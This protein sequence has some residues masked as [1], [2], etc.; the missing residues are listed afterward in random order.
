MQADYVTPPLQNAHTN[1]RWT[2]F[3][4]ISHIPFACVVLLAVYRHFYEIAVLV[5]LVLAISIP[6]HIGYERR[7]TIS[8]IDNCTA[9]TLSMYGNVQLF[10]SPLALILGINL[11]LGIVAGIIFALG[12]TRAFA[13]FYDCMHPIGLHIIPAVWCAVVVLFQRPFVF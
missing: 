3:H 9:F 7:T 2:D 11:S 6:C 1:Q 8:Y 10:F 4:V 5:T 13:P 12:Y